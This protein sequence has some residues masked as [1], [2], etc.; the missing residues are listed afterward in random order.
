METP[1]IELKPLPK[2]LKHVFL[3]LGYTFPIIISSE[4]SVVQGEKVLKMLNEHKSVLGW[5]VADIKGIS[6]LICSHRIHLE[7]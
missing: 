3:G 6:P 4:L 2:G 7:E 1:K 5:T